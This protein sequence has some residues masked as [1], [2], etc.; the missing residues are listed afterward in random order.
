MRLAPAALAAAL[1]T[2]VQIHANAASSFVNALTIPGNAIDLTPLGGLAGG[3]NV[4]QLGMFSDLYFDFATGTYYG[5]SD[6]GPGGG[7]IGYATRVQQFSLDVNAVTGQI[8]NFAVTRTIAFTSGGQNF[9]GLNPRLLNGDSRVL[10]LSH[11]PEGFV[12]GPTGKFY[13]SDEYGPSVQEFDSQGRLLRSF[14]LPA[15]IIAKQGATVNL[16]DGRP[17]ITTGRQDN[18]GFEGLAITPDGTRLLAV[19]QDP[20]VNEG[21]SNDGRRSRN[22]RLVEFDVASGT[23]TKQYI[24]QLE[25][26]ADINARLPSGAATFNATSQGRNIGLSG[27]YAIGNDE[28]LVLE[29][30]NRG[31]GVEDPTGTGN[32][33][34][35]KRVFRIILAGATDV[36]AIS[37]AG[38]SAL[39][40][41]VHPVGKSLYLDV[42]AAL[43]AQG[44]VI[45]EKLEGFAVGPRLADG[46][47]MLLLG[48]DNDYS[49]TQNGAGTQF[50]VC[51]DATQVA[52]DA[53]CPAGTTPI[54]GFLYA[55]RSVPGDIPAALADGQ[56]VSEPAS[57][58]LVAGGLL[59]LARARRKHAGVSG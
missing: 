28:F 21:D 45:P 56:Q 54:P 26:V 20:L 4:N 33:S 18:R 38:S 39:P 41:G 47:F 24:Y 51:T 32:P 7:T 46:S 31:L 52:L 19:L 14:T 48:T 59:A 50:L 55:F 1:I 6:R 25:A 2:A 5:L 27:V 40:V 57:V 42:L 49:V 44:L 13:V 11:D 29:R 30:D 3:V 36:A 15:N 9:N 37:L 35:S 16:V 22:V 43:Q 53:N 23:A 34:G 8:S 10:G 17:T 12:V 58:M